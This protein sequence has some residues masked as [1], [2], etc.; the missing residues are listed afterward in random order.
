MLLEK[1]EVMLSAATYFPIMKKEKPARK[2]KSIWM[3][4]WLQRR[5]FYGQYEKLVAELRGE[6]TKSFRNY[7]ISRSPSVK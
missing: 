7:I 5:V 1:E 6:D 4:T 3:K 2:K